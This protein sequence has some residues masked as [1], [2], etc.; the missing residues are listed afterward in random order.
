MDSLAV[1]VLTKYCT[2]AVVCLMC[3]RSSKGDRYMYVVLHS[4]TILAINTFA[5]YIVHSH[6]N[7]LP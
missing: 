7:R 6:T 1:C 5:V 3:V 2:E 4:F